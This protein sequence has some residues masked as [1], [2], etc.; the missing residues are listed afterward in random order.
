MGELRIAWWN[1]SLSPIAGGES[2]RNSEG[3]WETAHEVVRNLLRDQSVDVLALGEVTPDDVERL[4]DGNSEGYWAFVVEQSGDRHVD[5]AM[6]YNPESLTVARRPSLLT[7][8][9]GRALDTVALPVGFELVADGS[10]LWMF[11]V[12]WR[13]QRQRDGEFSRVEAAARLRQAIDTLRQ[14]DESPLGIVLGDFNDEP[15]SVAVE[16]HLRASRDRNLA[17]S[18]PATLYNPSW[19]LLG[20]RLPHRPGVS[21]RSIAGTH[22]YRDAGAPTHWYTY[23]QLI[24]TPAL[25]HE[26]AWNL[27]EDSVRVWWNEELFTPSG[28]MAKKFDHLPITATL[29]PRPPTVQESEH[30]RL[31]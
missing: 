13:S 3:R 7:I 21:S 30:E 20:E 4:R 18:S 19:R 25:V 8:S 2:T 6:L 28:A 23:D 12:H 31:P 14:G 22:Y 17:R 24:V 11:V 26:G 1:T 16:R 10:L 5:L 15:W 27:V 29:R 9:R